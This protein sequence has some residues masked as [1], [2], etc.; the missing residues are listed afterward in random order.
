MWFILTTNC[1]DNFA[2]YTNIKLL[3]C[4]PE[5]KMLLYQLSLD[6]EKESRTSFFSDPENVIEISQY[7]I[8][9]PFLSLWSLTNYLQA[10][11]RVIFLFLERRILCWLI[12]VYLS[13][14][15]SDSTDLQ[16]Y[17]TS[18]FK[19]ERKIFCSCC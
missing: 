5:M 17:P 7:T 12:G 15:N 16:M 18:S 10:I 14:I 19:C 1:G 6:Q 11:I 3:C 13:R 8:V 9:F 4:T 2:I